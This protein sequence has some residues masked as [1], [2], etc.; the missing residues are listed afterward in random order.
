LYLSTT[1]LSFA[2]FLTDSLDMCAGV[3]KDRALAPSVVGELLL[4]VTAHFSS[5]PA[6]MRR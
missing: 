4:C 3:N 6:G 2:P 1:A 5:V